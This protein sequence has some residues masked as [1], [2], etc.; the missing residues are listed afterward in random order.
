MYETNLN[1]RKSFLE[2]PLILAMLG[3]MLIGT[4][5]IYSAAFANESARTLSW[6]KQLYVKQ[7]IWYE[8]G[9]GFVIALCFFD[10]RTLARWS[11]IGYWG[12]IL[13]LILVLM[14]GSGG[15]SWGARRWINLGFFQFQPSEFTKIAFIFM[16]ANFLSRPVEELR[17]KT[18][19]FKALG[20]IALPFLLILKEPDL[21]SAL[22]F[23]PVGLL[24]MFVAGVPV[25]YVTAF[26][27]GVGLL[28]VL[29]LVD[30]LFVPI[31]SHW[32]V[33][34][35]EPYQRH[36]LLTYFGQDF[37][38]KNATPTERKQAQLLQNKRSYNVE[39]ALISVGSGGLT[40]K[41]WRQGTQYSLGF[42]PRAVAHNDFI[43]SV[44]AEEEG[45][46]GSVI[47]L[48]LYTVILF[49]GIKIASQARDRLGK[50]L[51]VGVVALLFSHIFINIGMNIRLM[52]VTGIP[53]PLLSYGGSSVLCSLIAI[54]ILQNVHMYRRAY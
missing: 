49:S 46:V 39:Q 3:L 31:D 45:F 12:T 26:V 36:R 37:A 24:M 51:A 10:Y 16:L 52:P 14:I 27:G 35:L 9:I 22:V 48:T 13:F 23:F 32:Q 1:E 17:S 6:F 42:L 40:G 11:I 15:A 7:I 29:I 19:F 38:P 33:I 21:G 8:I 28:M 4:A 50:I 5:F 30:V 47:V 34:K 41:G 44:I 54:G 53:L 18:L 25:K 43:F 20:M 2:W